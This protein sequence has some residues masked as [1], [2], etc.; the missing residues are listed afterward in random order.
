MVRTVTIEAFFGQ[1]IGEVENDDVGAPDEYE[2]TDVAPGAP[3]GR[4][5]EHGKGK[6][7]GNPMSSV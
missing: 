4:V 1:V 6:R 5:Y 3:Y 2:F 7:L